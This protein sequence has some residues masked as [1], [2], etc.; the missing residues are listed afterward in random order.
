MC[1]STRQVLCNCD[2]LGMALVSDEYSCA[3]FRNDSCVLYSVLHSE[4]GTREWT[5]TLRDVGRVWNRIFVVWL[6]AG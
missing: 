1:P 3:R 5:E 4:L 6:Q 2:A